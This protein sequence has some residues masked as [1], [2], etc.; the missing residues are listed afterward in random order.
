FS[1]KL[2]MYVKRL[3]SRFGPYATT[4]G[5]IVYTGASLLRQLPGEGIMLATSSG[6]RGSRS[7][8]APKGASESAT[9][10]ATAAGVAMIPAS[11][12]PLT[13]PTVKGDGEQQ[14]STSI[15]GTSVAPG[16]R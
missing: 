8:T 9:A 7:T 13:P 10:L 12:M 11:P 6:V 16:S 15:G 14:C 4:I 2:C 1:P 5:V 3:F